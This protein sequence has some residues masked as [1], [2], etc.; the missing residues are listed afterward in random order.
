ME[1]GVIR[2]TEHKKKK[3]E[4]YQESV[5]ES[6]PEPDK[7]PDE[8]PAL[9]CR[10]DLTAVE[11]LA[12]YQALRLYLRALTSQDTD[13]LDTVSIVTGILR[14]LRPAALKVAE[15]LKPQT[16]TE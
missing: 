15:A 5:I 14:T 3:R 7:A 6:E 16:Q 9:L 1:D 11:T 4:L 8:T 12:T 2:I 10:L 13:A